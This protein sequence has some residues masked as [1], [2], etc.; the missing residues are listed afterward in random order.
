MAQ[1]S[2]GGEQYKCRVCRAQVGLGGGSEVN[3]EY[4]RYKLARERRA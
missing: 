3:I 1:V 2:L 4:V